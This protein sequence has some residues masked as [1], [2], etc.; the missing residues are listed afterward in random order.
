MVGFPVIVCASGR[1][2]VRSKFKTGKTNTKNTISAIKKFNTRLLWEQLVLTDN[3]SNVSTSSIYAQKEG[4][5]DKQM[6]QK[7]LCKL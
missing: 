7:L 3:F 4:C 6:S 5:L 2:E 1:I